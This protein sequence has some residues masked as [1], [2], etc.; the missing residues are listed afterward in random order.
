MQWWKYS[1]TFVTLMVFMFDLLVEHDSY[2]KLKFVD[3]FVLTFNL[4]TYFWLQKL[5]PVDR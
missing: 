3:T 5:P 4:W 2:M 1:T